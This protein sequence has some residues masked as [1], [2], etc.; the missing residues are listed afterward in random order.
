[1]AW[2]G[3]SNEKCTA[4]RGAARQQRP[5]GTPPSQQPQGGDDHK[6]TNKQ[7]ETHALVQPSAWQALVAG[8]HL[9]SHVGMVLLGLLEERLLYVGLAAGQA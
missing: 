2:Y 6:Q 7:T 5:A 9:I 3:N 1:M 8:N 4:C